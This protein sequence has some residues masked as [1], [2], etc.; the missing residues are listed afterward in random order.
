MVV[1]GPKSLPNTNVDV[2]YAAK[3]IP[4]LDADSIEL[5]NIGD[6]AYYHPVAM[7][8]RCFHFLGAYLKTNDTVFVKRTEKYVAKMLTTAIRIDSALF[9]PYPFDYRVHKK[10]ALQLK[11]PWFSA[12]AQGEFLSIATRLFEYTGDSTYLQLAHQTFR[13]LTFLYNLNQPW[14]SRIDTAGYFWLEEYTL[15]EPDQT[16]NGFIAAVYGVYDYFRVTQTDDARRMYDNCLTTLKHYLPDYQR[17]DSLS[18]YCL[19]HR[20]VADSGYHRLHIS[21]CREL[22]RVSGDST[23]LEMARSLNAD[24]MVV[25]DLK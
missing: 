18:F 10:A 9:L 5:T 3:Y 15:P 11:A 23:F 20:H 22:L 12:M 17:P 13:S 6:S 14:V 25:P 8:H 7:T 2:A 19:G 1:L 24:V 21:M 16:L 4:P